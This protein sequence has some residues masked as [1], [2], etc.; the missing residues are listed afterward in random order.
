M[1]CGG[2]KRGRF[3]PE[4]REEVDLDGSPDVSFPQLQQRLPH[5]DPG[6]VDQHVHLP[7]LTVHPED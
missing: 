4:S 5:Q 7:Y 3:Y 2:E 1:L 6:I